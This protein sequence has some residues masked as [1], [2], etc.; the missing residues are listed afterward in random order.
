[1]WSTFFE[2]A[3]FL[4]SYFWTFTVANWENWKLSVIWTSTTLL[5]SG[6][7][8]RD[9]FF[10]RANYFAK[11]YSFKKW[12]FRF[13]GIPPARSPGKG[14]SW[15]LHEEAT[16]TRKSIFEMIFFTGVSTREVSCVRSDDETPASFNSCSKALKP[17]SQQICNNP[18]CNPE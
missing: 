4:C 8:E 15:L 14:R 12:M 6:I 2:F 3:V 1:M 9:K 16:Y 11:V 18:S 10:Q 17:T 13:T 7:Q 5:L